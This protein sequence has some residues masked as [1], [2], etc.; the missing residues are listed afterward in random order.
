MTGL[1]TGFN[2]Q[3]LE[4]MKADGNL[5]SRELGME[6]SLVRDKLF[7]QGLSCSTVMKAVKHSE[8]RPNAEGSAVNQE[9]GASSGHGTEDGDDEEESD[10]EMEDSLTMDPDAQIKLVGKG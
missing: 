1:T 4:K 3:A 7:K 6:I 9:A 5:T 2:L 8:V 10:D